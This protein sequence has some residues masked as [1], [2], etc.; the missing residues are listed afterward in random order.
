[1]LKTIAANIAAELCRADPVNK[2]AYNQN[3]AALVERIDAVHQQ[4]QKKLAPYRGRAFYVF[5]PGFAYFADAYGLRESP[6][7][8]GGQSPSLKQVRALTAQAQ[9][10]RVRTIFIQPEFDPESVRAIADA[11]HGQVVPINGLAKDVIADIADIAAKIEKSMQES[12]TP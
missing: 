6:V 9:K 11:I 2:Q 12:S 1:L 3:L 7:Q 10:D 8:V 4:N 5:H